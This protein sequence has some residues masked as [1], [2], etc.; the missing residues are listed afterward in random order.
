[1]TGVGGSG[2]NWC[3]VAQRRA[4]P[5]PQHPHTPEFSDGDP[6]TARALG[7]GSLALRA[8]PP[9]PPPARRAGLLQVH[10]MDRAAL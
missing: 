5:P 3:R 1:M 6:R 8:A 2:G 9:K 10:A 4:E 7:P